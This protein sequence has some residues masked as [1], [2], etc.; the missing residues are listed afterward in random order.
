MRGELILINGNIYTQDPACPRAQGVAIRG[1]RFIAVHDDDHVLARSW[2]GVQ[3]IDLEGRTVLPGLTDAHLHY[4]GWALGRRRL[5]LVAATS[6]A[7]LQ[8][9]LKARAA[10]TSPGQ[11]ILGQGW[12]ES[13]W[14]DPQM[15]RRWDLDAVAPEHPVVLWRSDFHLAVVN[16][17]ALQRAGIVPGTQAPPGG[18]IGRDAHGEPDGVLCDEALDL[19]GG[20]LP[21]PT[22]EELLDSMRRGFIGL[23]RL[24]LTGV[25]AFPGVAGTDDAVIF[26]AYQRLAEA[27]DLDV[28]TWMLLPGGH[29]DAAVELGLRTGCGNGLLRVG[30]LKYFADGSQGAR[31]AWL[32][33]PYVGGEDCGLPQTPIAEIASAVRRADRAG[34]SAAI[35]AIGDR[36]I[37]ELLLALAPIVEE[38]QRRETAIP[39][40]PH[41]IEHVQITQPEDSARLAGLGLIASVQPIHAT[42]DITMVGQTIGSRGRWAYAFRDMLRAGVTLAFGSDAPVADPNPLWGIHAAVT[43]RRRDGTPAGGWY[44]TQR[45][46][47]EEAVWAYTMGPAIAAGMRAEL[48]SISAGKWADLTVLDRD[49]FHVDPMEIADACAVMTVVAGDV[50]YR[51]E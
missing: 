48:G 20:V 28:R 2:P 33:E 43:R 46:T 13:D 1:G 40:A 5:S 50:V 27:S 41:R 9:A 45:L 31:T 14:P 25:H 29:L 15:P 49:I 39:A 30:H 3:V 19:L 6:L 32:S 34:L 8:A 11:W 7:D 24:G 37:H 26:R 35:H 18:L 22:E 12:N 38:R 10:E 21:A 44:P 51:V 42:D 16:S 36:A 23:H 17:A 47:V 4:A